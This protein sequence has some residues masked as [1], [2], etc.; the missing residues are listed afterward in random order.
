[1]TPTTWR[2]CI[3]LADEVSNLEARRNQLVFS[4]ETGPDVD[5]IIPKTFAH[6]S[7]SAVIGPIEEHVQIQDA[8]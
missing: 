2:D 3:G 8:T 1:M 6:G 5:Y 7:F 4:T